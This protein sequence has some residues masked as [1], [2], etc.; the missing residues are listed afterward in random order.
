MPA[1]PAWLASLEAMLNRRIGESAAAQGAA[2]RLEASSLVLQIEGV[3]SVR[4]HV[5]GGRLFV[6]PLEPASPP[7]DVCI[8][9]TPGALA[10]MGLRARGVDVSGTGPRSRVHIEGDAQVA[11]QFRELLMSARPELEEELARHVGD[12]PAR[13]IARTVQA[14]AG[15]VRRAQRTAEQNLAEYL[16]E[17][18]RALVGRGELE[19]FFIEVDRLRETADRVEARLARLELALLRSAR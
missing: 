13:S 16:T 7:P 11:G 18:S 5:R 15:F 17:E 3:M 10:A 12:L 6:G 9:G 2:R 8:R 14:V 4:L 1:T 19:E